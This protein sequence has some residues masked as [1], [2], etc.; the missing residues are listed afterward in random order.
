MPIRSFLIAVILCST[1]T[2]ALGAQAPSPAPSAAGA[3]TAARVAVAAIARSKPVIDGRL[4]DAVWLDAP[5]LSGFVQRE[6]HEGEPVSE[7]TEVRVISDGEA[8]YIGAWMYDRTPAG[9]VPGE[10]IRDVSLDNSDYVAIIFDTF[11]DRQN[12]FVFATTPA[13]IEYDGQVAK[14]GEGGGVQQSNQTRAAAGSMGGFNINWDATWEVKTSMDSAGWYAEFRI[15]YSTLRYAGGARQSWGLNVGRGIRR[16]GEDAYWAFVPRQFNIYRLSRAGTL[17][18]TQLPTP[19]LAVVTPY[20]LG[21]SNQNFALSPIGHRDAQWGADVKYG[22]TPSLTLD[23]TYNTD[24]AQVEV[25]QQQTNLTRFPLFF[26]EKRPF[27]LENAGS[28]SAGTPQSVDLFF[29]RRIGID[30]LGQAVPIRGG[31]RLSGRVAGMTLGALE[32]VTDDDA[33]VQPA[34]SYTVARLTREV[35]RRS[36]VGA[37][38]VQRV[39]VD[40]AGD[41]NGTYGL[42]GRVGLGEA[43]TLDGWG[44]KTATPGSAGDE[45]GYSARAAYTTARWNNSARV[46]SVGDAFNPEVGFLTRTGGFR[47]Y[48]LALMRLVR[49]SNLKWL[50]DWN[51]HVSIRNYYRPDGYYESGWLHMDLTE[52]EL[53]NGGKFGPEFNVYHEGLQ[54]PFEISPGVTLPVGGYTYP[55]LGLDWTTNPSA[56]FNVVLRSDVGG[57]YDG[58]RNGQ[59]LTLTGRRGATISTSLTYDY[60]RVWLD[61]G[62]FTRNLIQTR[63]AYFFTPR[64]FVQSL[65][66]YSNQARAWSAN[67]RFAWLSAAGTGLFVVYNDGEMADSFFR[68]RQPQSRS[69]VI[70][71]ARQ[72]GTGI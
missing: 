9:I 13:G 62:D 55:S 18:L 22:V 26:P 33:G 71:Y 17:E 69:L 23:L 11:H 66:Q 3:S 20:V 32:I 1:I 53:A 15:P 38:A 54:Q 27:F 72:F 48:E 8:L 51:P 2:A 14:E 67:T 16:K 49:D 28:F 56:P 30:T 34:N 59:T 29:S 64:I 65:M 19:R 35:S 46:V 21:S 36:R 45:F 10:K 47:Y 43:W 41:R 7:R 57:F 63:V 5:L 25:D 31:G 4:D 6:L 70:K 60:Q 42:D 58:T 50:K 12:G 39:A 37:I 44:A 68:W 40:S 24:F 61:E 52:L